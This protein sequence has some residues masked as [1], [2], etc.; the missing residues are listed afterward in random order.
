MKKTSKDLNNRKHIAI[1]K[2]CNSELRATLGGE[3]ITCGMDGD[4]CKK[5]SVVVGMHDNH[6][7]VLARSVSAAQ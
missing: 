7:V 2:L 6:K 5:L 3:I 4:L 1:H